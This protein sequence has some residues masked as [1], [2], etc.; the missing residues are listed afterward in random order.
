M[1]SASTEMAQSFSAV[2]TTG[3]SSSGT[4]RQVSAHIP[5]LLS[6]CYCVCVCVCAG[7]C[8]GRFTNTKTPYCVRFNPDE[9]KQGLFVVGCSDKKI[10]TVSLHLCSV[11][12][13]SNST[14]EPTHKYDVMLINTTIIVGAC[15]VCCGKCNHE[16]R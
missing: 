14:F 3:T 15:R 8:V 7:Q 10:Y 9:D 6:H 13:C 4:Q 5:S 12:A 2:A 11:Y 1:T 16:L